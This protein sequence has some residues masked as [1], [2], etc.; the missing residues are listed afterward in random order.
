MDSL[1]NK[2]KK[3][4]LAEIQALKDR[5]AQLERSYS[6][7]DETN[8]EFRFQKALEKVSLLALNLDQ[9]GKIYYCNK[10]FEDFIGEKKSNLIGKDWNEIIVK[11]KGK[12]NTDF[13]RFSEKE[14]FINNIKRKILSKDG[15]LRTVKFH[16]V[17]HL[18]SNGST[19]G[20]SLFGEDITEKKRV[21]KALRESNQLL[22]DL[23]E[24]ANDLIQVSSLDG[25]VLFVNNAWKNTL[26]YSDKEIKNLK[27]KDI[28]HEDYQNATLKHLEKILEGKAG[29]KI[30]TVFKT[31]AGKG[32]YVIGSV[33]VRYEKDT[34]VAFRGIFHDTTEKIRAER[35]QN[36]YYKIANLAINSNNLESLL[37]NIHQEL[38]KFVAVNNFH[39]ALYD[40]EKNYLNFPYYIDENHGDKVT[41]M[42]RPVGKGLTEYSLFNERP[43]FLYEED[44]ISLV[45]EHR[46]EPHG[47]IPKIWIGVP[48]RLENRTIG[49]IAV[50]SHSDRNKF[51]IRHL[52]L[53][54]FISG[55]I[56]L[57]IERKR[58][59]DKIHEQTARLNS[60]F[61]S[62][63]HLIWSVNRQRGLTS[64][65]HNYAEAIKKKF[66]IH[67][68][69]FTGNENPA[70]MMLANKE[71]HDFVNERYMEAFEGKPQHFETKSG[72]ESGEV[73]W[74]E[75]YLN[76]IFLPDGRIEEVS[77]ISHDIT[78]KK[79]WELAI[80]ESEEK[81]RNIFESF[82][83][84]YYRTDVRGKI[85]MVS[86]SG[87]ELSGFKE[88]E[89]IGKH[90]TDFYVSPKK[91]SNLIRQ[92]LKTG[93]VQNYENNLILKDGRI[94]QSISNIR[95]I[96]NK[97]GKPVAVDGVARD[98]T[99]LKQA[100]EEF[101]K[102]K[103]IAE[104]SLKV[105]ESFLANMSHEI[106]TPMNGII[107][108]IDL[109]AG[110][111]LDEEQKKYVQTIKKSSETLLTILN[112]I[113]DLS[114]IEAGKMQLRLTSISLEST[115][116]KLYSLFHQQAASKNLDFSY[117]IHEDVPKYI[118]AD[119]IRLLQILSNLTSNSIKFTDHG[120]IKIK[121][122]LDNK[123]GTTYR[124]KVEICD[125]GIGISDENINKLF[126][127]FNQLDTSST[128][129]YAGTGLGLA[130]SKEL[131]KMMNGQIGVNSVLG[132]GSTFWFTFEAQ[133]SKRVAALKSPGAT[134]TPLAGNFKDMQPY[135][136][137][138][139]DNQINQFVATEILKKAGCKTDTAENGIAAIEKVKQ[140]KYDLIFMDI[141]M[142][143]MDG[144]T[145][146][147]EISRILKDQRPPIIA[148]TAYSMKEDK[149]KFI[150]SGMDDYVSKP[151]KP[152]HLINK[153]KEWIKSDIKN[154]EESKAKTNPSEGILNLNVLEKLKAFANNETLLKIYHD[155]EME[156]LEQIDACKKCSENHDINEILS[157]LHTLKGTAGTLGVEKVEKLAKHLESNLK[158]DYNYNKINVDL[159]E[160]DQAFSEFQ[161][162][163]KSIFNS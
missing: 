152:E 163:Y 154:P 161:L 59:E 93:T 105:K 86:P 51:K 76:P 68:E 64:F 124:M 158:T 134:T 102:A 21:I 42:Q 104:R 149:D 45:D 53:L 140:N 82:Q 28:L 98:I 5:I 121:I 159:Q 3:D 137:L 30:E 135:I 26:G 11:D 55:Q 115:I 88:E 75:T 46:V 47:A 141:Q 4:L 72:E 56:A 155:F 148:M 70:I 139:D 62:S 91:Q 32:I 71:Y 113:L 39:V 49:V 38:K 116:E 90:V 142:P 65:N 99:Y 150:N 101:V 112:D 31:K 110:T 108:M 128:K 66:G 36:L 79:N 132:Q 136:L 63:S 10:A 2:E 96:Y 109:L 61:E 87:C 58:N 18:N 151:I 94:V 34:P 122:L 67:P 78:E 23:F 138:V 43:T 35:A 16:L 20:I 73:I 6:V 25:D 157:N 83:D 24:N 14:N 52:E 106:R 74:R 37:F 129:A 19:A 114:K 125:T 41:T 89:I 143:Q 133:E 44:I 13:A 1:E 9:N 123:K 120:S 50:K 85:T 77:G 81:F 117:E 69:I 57:V 15:I 127:S 145:A 147:Q 160:L 107:G 144:I 146:S 162:H 126:T 27:L 17:R 95:L 100:S 130:I 54:D 8:P 153:V 92:L 84:I 119:E 80:Q 131:C 156:A 33:N 111:I 97:E 29:D 22:Q 118:L 60:I 40:K 103:E 12:E 48:L 7:N